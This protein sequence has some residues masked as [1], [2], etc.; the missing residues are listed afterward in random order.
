MYIYLRLELRSVLLTA[1][2][3]ACPQTACTNDYVYFSE[4]VT[5]IHNTE[6][7]FV[8]LIMVHLHVGAATSGGTSGSGSGPGF[9]SGKLYTCSVRF[10]ILC[11]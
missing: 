8:I 3:L 2:A 5:S 6:L 7:T 11:D 10:E 4:V 1:S 9:W